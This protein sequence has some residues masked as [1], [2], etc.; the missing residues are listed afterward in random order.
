M[1]E[2]FRR[3]EVSWRPS[4][5]ASRSSVFSKSRDSKSTT[6]HKGVTV[7][8]RAAAYCAATTRRHAPQI[9]RRVPPLAAPPS[10]ATGP[11]PVAA[12]RAG[13]GDAD[14]FGML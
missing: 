10:G 14:I 2:E 5:F 11:L 4:F 7:R 13:H 6:T 12:G 8:R 3:T 1:D 9:C